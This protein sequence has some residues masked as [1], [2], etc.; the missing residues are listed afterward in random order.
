[1]ASNKQK[2]IDNAIQQIES[3]GYTTSLEATNPNKPNQIQQLHVYKGE[4]LVARVSLMLACRID[5]LRNG[6]G[7]NEKDLLKVLVDLSMNL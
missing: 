7:R 2:S 3:L 5:T 6:V 4:L 1:M